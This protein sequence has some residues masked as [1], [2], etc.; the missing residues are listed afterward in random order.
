MAEPGGSGAGARVP[1]VEVVY[2]LPHEQ[3][4]VSVVLPPEGLTAA[5]AVQS[6]GLVVAYPEL[7]TQP[8]VLGVYGTVCGGERRLRDGDRVEIYRPLRTDPRASRRERVAGTQRK[9]W[10]RTGRGAAGRDPG[11]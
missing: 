11:T 8:L 1:T 2:A 5:A 4:V 9:G 6:S 3:Q 7:A 10:K